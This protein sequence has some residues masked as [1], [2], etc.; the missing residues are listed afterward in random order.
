MKRSSIFLSVCLL[1][2]CYDVYYQQLSADEL[3]YANTP[4]FKIDNDQ[5]PIASIQNSIESVVK[6]S[7]LDKV[8][9]FSLF[10]K[11]T[12]DLSVLCSE[13]YSIRK[14]KQNNVTIQGCAYGIP[15]VHPGVG[16][17]LILTF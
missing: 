12:G 2:F 16:S 10:D 13:P 8:D 11:Q 15:I 6:I 17:I 14:N 1:L 9:R 5:P 3:F 7:S 4:D